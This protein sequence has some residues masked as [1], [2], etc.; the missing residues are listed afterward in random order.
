MLE[1]G[2]GRGEEVK[3]RTTYILGSCRECNSNI[4]WVKDPKILGWQKPPILRF[5]GEDSM[6]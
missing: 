3:A 4:P 5:Q 6:F 1:E 2:K